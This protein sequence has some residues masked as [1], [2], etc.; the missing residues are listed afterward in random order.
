MIMTNKMV[1]TTFVLLHYDNDMHFSLSCI[2]DQLPIM[3][4]IDR[5]L[6]NP[7]HQNILE[8]AQCIIDVLQHRSIDAMISVY[9]IY[10]L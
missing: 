2:D 1:I 8:F 3:F 10:C 7:L 4:H 6:D 5:S 9:N